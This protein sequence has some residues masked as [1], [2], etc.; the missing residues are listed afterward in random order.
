VPA[1]DT[2][3]LLSTTTCLAP[4]E[5]PS[6]SP[7]VAAAAEPFTFADVPRLARALRE[8]DAGAFRFLHAEWNQR[9]LRYC[10][11]LAAGDGAFATEI[12]QAT[13]LR[14]FKQV[15]PLPDEAALW[16][17]ITRAMRSATID[18]RRVG[19]RYRRAL[20]RFANWLRFGFG[21]RPN[22][23]SESRMFAALDHAL[24]NLEPEERHLIDC[25]YFQ[26]EPLEAIAARCGTTARAIEGRLARIRA[27]LRSNIIS[28]LRQDNL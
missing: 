7:R 11:A 3:V 2:S 22:A 16:N 21:A 24:G 15:Q 13:Y 27:R 8:G 18:F 19:G 12:A 6:E 4:V 25:R 9:I 28:A 14:I 10:F 5:L 1:T 17:W 26:R 20:G 23:A